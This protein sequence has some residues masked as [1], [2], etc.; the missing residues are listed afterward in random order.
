M[1]E[2]SEAVGAFQQRVTVTVVRLQCRFLQ[3]WQAGS[4]SSLVKMHS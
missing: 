1:E 4:S 3:V 2:H